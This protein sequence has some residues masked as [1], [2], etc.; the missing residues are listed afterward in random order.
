MRNIINIIYY[1]ND[2]TSIYEYIRTCKSVLRAY[3]ASDPWKLVK[4]GKTNGE[5]LQIF[6]NFYKHLPAQGSA[7]WLKFRAG[8]ADAPPIIGGSEIATLLGVN[9]Y[10]SAIELI[11]TKSGLKEFR[12]N[13]ATRWGNIFEDVLFMITDCIFNIETREMGS[14]PGLRDDAGY[15]LTSFS[16]DRIALVELGKFMPQVKR[17]NWISGFTV[18]NPPRVIELINAGSADNHIIL[19]EAKCPL[20]RAPNGK[21]P[22]HYEPQIL[23][24]LSTIPIASFCVFTDAMF[25]KCSLAQMSSGSYDDKFHGVMKSQYKCI[26]EGFIGFYKK[27]RKDNDHIVSKAADV[28]HTA[29]LRE[30][31]DIQSEYYEF[32]D[33]AHIMSLCKLCDSLL[34][35]TYTT[36]GINSLSKHDEEQIVVRAID[37]ALGC[38]HTQL[39]EQII[40]DALNVIYGAKPSFDYGIDYGLASEDELN[41]L[42]EAALHDKFSADGIKIYYSPHFCGALMP[43]SDECNITF[44][45]KQYAR[46]CEKYQYKSIG[47]LPWKLF[48]I[49]YV[50]YAGEP[51]FLDKH[52]AKI[53][54]TMNLI[55][56]VRSSTDPLDAFTDIQIAQNPRGAKSSNRAKKEPIVFDN[57]FINNI[58]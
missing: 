20:R 44:A 1:L 40:P 16:P 41:A 2:I 27:S 45:I 33:I 36:C 48:N 46:I 4:L 35:D 53:I 42:F 29:I 25:R 39:I 7:E 11:A 56:K 17:A 5:K 31:N 10:Q 14:I 26:M 49:N 52:R 21:V 23:M 47:I 50:P 6:I 8:N 55:K 30:V 43:H 18:A 54:D 34:N 28:L 51:G 12:G 37:K 9:P 38:A 3:R 58:L 32:C 24:G 13:I 19:F 57:E 22:H 15:P